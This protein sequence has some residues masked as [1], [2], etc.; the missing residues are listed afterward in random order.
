MTKKLYAV[1][2]S[3][4]KGLS[5]HGTLGNSPM[6]GTVVTE[7]KYT[8]VSLGGFPGVVKG[9]NTSITLEIYDVKHETI[10]QNLDWLEGYSGPNDEYN[11]YNKEIIETELGP[12]YI[13][14]INE[15]VNGRPLVESGDWKQYKL[16]N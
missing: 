8:M 9:G 3:L 15:D 16:N 4:R 5:N 6:V 7:P 1:Y 13:Y 11:F 14:Y 2:G 12:A 10:E